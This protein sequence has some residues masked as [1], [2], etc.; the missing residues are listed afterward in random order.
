MSGF[1]PQ[2]IINQVIE[3]TD[4]VPVVEQYVKLSKKSSANY[5]GLCPFHS[6]TNSS[7]SVSPGKQIYYC[8]S[9]Q[10]GG[11]VIKFLQDIE[12]ITF[13]EAVRML[14]Q[15][16]NLVIPVGDSKQYQENQ[17]ERKIQQ[18]LHL[19]AVRFF[20]RNLDSNAE[21]HIKEYMLQSPVHKHI[22]YQLVQV[23]I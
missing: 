13:P 3:Q 19:E 11:N 1:I 8:F 22:S 2:E 12:N 20:Y 15:R 17:T 23:E 18:N 10:K 16:L 5:F 14:A 7:F 4:I 9:C 21:K 6:E